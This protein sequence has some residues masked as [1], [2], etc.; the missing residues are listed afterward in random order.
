M[1]LFLIWYW[2]F[3][4]SGLNLRRLRTFK[5]LKHRVIRFLIVWKVLKVGNDMLLLWFEQGGCEDRLLLML[6]L[7]LAKML[8]R[9]GDHGA[10]RLNRIQARSLRRH[11]V[12]HILVTNRPLAIFE[13]VRWKHW[14][15]ITISFFR[16]L[17][18]RIAAKQGVAAANERLRPLNF[19]PKLLLRIIDLNW[20]RF[21]VENVIG[22]LHLNW[23]RRSNLTVVNNRTLM[24][25]SARHQRHITCFFPMNGPGLLS[26][27]L[28]R[29]PSSPP[30]ILKLCL[31]V[32]TT[33][34]PDDSLLQV[35]SRLL[36]S[37]KR[38]LMLHWIH[39]YYLMIL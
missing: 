7:D 4:G 38:A 12:I 14:I 29:G 10:Q 5:L 3:A 27:H 34:I 18:T 8:H 31:R 39:L 22:I 6:R 26:Q 11:R 32:G 28:I 30:N 13:Y 15:L 21:F 25:G 9:V 17:S 2:D 24:R 35:S 33:P 19:H 36:S 23:S 1:L 16:R 20:H 37:L